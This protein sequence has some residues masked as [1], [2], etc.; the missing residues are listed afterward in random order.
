LLMVSRR[1]FFSSFVK[2]TLYFFAGIDS[3]PFGDYTSSIYLYTNYVNSDTILRY[4]A[5]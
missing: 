2:V 4:G 1:I 3:L 5:E